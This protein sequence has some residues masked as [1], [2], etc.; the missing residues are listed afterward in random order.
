MVSRLQGNPRKFMQPFG[1][2]FHFPFLFSGEALLNKNNK[3]AGEHRTKKHV[4][5]DPCLVSR[6]TDEFKSSDE[7]VLQNP[8]LSETTRQVSKKMVC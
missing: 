3:A 1:Q 4:P 7:Q 2:G 6:K 5:Q 8:N